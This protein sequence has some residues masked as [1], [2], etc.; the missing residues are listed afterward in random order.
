[1]SQ[2]VKISFAL[3]VSV[4]DVKA[5]C[6]LLKNVTDGLFGPEEAVNK[7]SGGRLAE[8]SQRIDTS[9]GTTHALMEVAGVASRSVVLVG[10]GP[11][12]SLTYDHVGAI[13]RRGTEAALK[14]DFE[15]RT[16]ATVIHA[17]GFGLA[18]SEVFKAEL[19]GFKKAL[20]EAGR[21]GE[22]V[23]EIVFSIGPNHIFLYDEI[24]KALSAAHDSAFRLESDGCFLEIGVA[25]R[26]EAQ[27]EQRVKQARYVFVA[28]PY[29]R[30]FE[31]VFD[32]GMRL[33]IEECGL[34]PVRV[35]KEAFSGSISQEIKRRLQQSLLVI[36]DVTDSNPNVLYELGYAE[37]CAIP[38]IVVCQKREHAEMP[39]DLRDVNTLFYENELLRNLNRDLLLRIRHVLEQRQRD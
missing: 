21:R 17:V 36:A 20:E 11:A 31:N 18:R 32:F 14:L 3:G 22:S 34:L 23:Q 33:P 16:I 4:T 26:A 29:K 9:L 2:R 30:E 1:M 8:M 38:T 35:D 37:G 13:C 5:D 10:V 19:F 7:A 25:S 27:F 12:A 6:L 15:I 28:M 24:L 39:F